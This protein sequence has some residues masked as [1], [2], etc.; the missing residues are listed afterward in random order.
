MWRLFSM[1]KLL[2][3]FKKGKFKKWTH[4]KKKENAQKQIERREK[5]MSVR[6]MEFWKFVFCC[7]KKIF[8]SKQ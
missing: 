7:L 3:A 8:L 4:Q 6:S 1:D 2:F 5:K